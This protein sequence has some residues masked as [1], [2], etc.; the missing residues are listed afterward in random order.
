M[1]ASAFDPSDQENIDRKIA[2]GFERLAQVL[3]TL[4]WNE[5]KQSGLSP[6]QIQFL[7]TLAFHANKEWTLSSLASYFHLTSATVSDALTALEDKG[8]IVRRQSKDDRRVGHLALTA[9]GRRQALKLAGWMD[10]VVETVHDLDDGDK[11]V[12]LKSLIGII[13]ALQQ[14]GLISVVHM[15]MTCKYFRPNAHPSKAKPHHCA[16]VDKAFGDA[17][18]RLDCPDYEEQEATT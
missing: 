3:K 8:L 4:V 15:C 16:Y 11:A 14:K 2:F 13:A 9:A 17:E 18:L 10:A 6:I 7:I 5:S 12:V 1:P